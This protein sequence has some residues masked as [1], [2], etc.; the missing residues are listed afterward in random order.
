MLRPEWGRLVPPRD[1]DG[2]ARAVTDLLAL[3]GDRRA[4]MGA[5]GRAFVVENGNVHTETAKLSRLLAGLPALEDQGPEP[6][7]GV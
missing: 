7:R 1:V 2:L 5:Q 4:G 6:D 3:P